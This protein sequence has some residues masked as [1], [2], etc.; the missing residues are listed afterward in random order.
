MPSSSQNGIL[1]AILNFL[2]PGLGYWYLGYRK[3]FGIHP[4]LFLIAVWVVEMVIVF[5]VSSLVPFFISLFL[6]CDA[7]L[8]S[9]GNAAWV[10]VARN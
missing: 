6:A 3:V 9:T 7:Y 5:Y 4:I 1:G 2:F 10:S 8:K